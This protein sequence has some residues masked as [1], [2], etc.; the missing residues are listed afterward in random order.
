M[1]KPLGTSFKTFEGSPWRFLHR[2]ARIFEGS[3]WR[4]LH[5]LLKEVTGGFLQG[6]GASFI[7]GRPERRVTK[8]FR[9]SLP[10]VPRY[11]RGIH[12][13][14]AD[15]RPARPTPS[16]AAAHQ[17]EPAGF[18]RPPEELLPRLLVRAEPGEPDV[19]WPGEAAAT[20]HEDADSKQPEPV[21]LGEVAQH[22]EP[23]PF[24]AA[25]PDG[26]LL[27]VDAQRA[28]FSLRWYW[29]GPG[30]RRESW[31]LRGGCDLLAG[32]MPS[33]PKVTGQQ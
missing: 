13:S 20:V 14:P 26:S 25:D 32:A 2:T 27:I 21:L 23:L 30:F 11:R 8:D 17:E 4:F 33:Y 10:H 16:P 29:S 3:P 12:R 28:L 18:D 1:G 31:R 9:A 15:G 5:E 7:G 19:S 6:F 24:E 22:E